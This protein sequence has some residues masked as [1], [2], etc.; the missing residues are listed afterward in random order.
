MTIELIDDY[1]IYINLLWLLVG[2]LNPSEKYQSIG[3]IIPNIWENKKC[4]KP[5]TRNWL[6]WSSF[7]INLLWL[8]ICPGDLGLTTFF[9]RPKKNTLWAHSPN[10]DSTVQFEIWI[11]TNLWPSNILP[12]FMIVHDATGF[13]PESRGILCNPQFMAI[14]TW[15]EKNMFFQTTHGKS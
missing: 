8:I 14:Q 9:R 7:Y 4:S 11:A 10:M 15:K 2:G 6:M 3:M 13:V 1:S 12:S 5:P